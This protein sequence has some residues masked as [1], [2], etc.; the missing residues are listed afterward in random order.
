VG[1][2]DGGG[3]FAIMRMCQNPI[4]RVSSDTHAL[5]DACSRSVQQLRGFVAGL[6]CI[7]SPAVELRIKV[8]M[9]WLRGQQGRADRG[10]EGRGIARNK[11]TK[12]PH[13]KTSAQFYVVRSIHPKL[14]FKKHGNASTHQSVSYLNAFPR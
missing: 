10:G 3:Q 9:A 8:V 7:Q 12:H 1:V 5:L 14:G 11:H 2:A 6:V 13:S 4:S